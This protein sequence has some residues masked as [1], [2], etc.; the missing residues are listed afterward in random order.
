MLSVHLALFV[1]YHICMF[2]CLYLK[3]TANRLS[4]GDQQTHMA[5]KLHSKHV[6]LSPPLFSAGLISPNPVKQDRQR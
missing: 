2:Q 4:H 6:F 1:F 3:V 5:A